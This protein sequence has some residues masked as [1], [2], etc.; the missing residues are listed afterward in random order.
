[1]K[2]KTPD[3]ARPIEL[4]KIWRLSQ[5]GKLKIIPALLF[6]IT[7][8]NSTCKKPGQDY[9]HNPSPAV[10]TTITSVSPLS[11][12]SG[13]TIIIVGTNFNT[14]P[15][16]DTVK[17]D[18]LSAQ[19]ERATK[20]TLFVIVPQGNGSGSVTVNG[21]LAPGPAFAII[22]T[23]PIVDTP[24]HKNIY[25]R[26][27]EFPNNNPVPNALVGL[28]YIIADTSGNIIS[29]NSY[30]VDSAYSDQNGGVYFSRLD[31]IAKLH[32]TNNFNLTSTKSNFWP[33]TNDFTLGQSADSS[34][35][36][37]FSFAWIAAHIKETVNHP[38]TPDIRIYFSIGDAV[39]TQNSPAYPQN[40]LDHLKEFSSV[41]LDT[42]VLFRTCGSC[43]NE[44]SIYN[45]LNHTIANQI[46]DSKPIANKSDTLKLEILLP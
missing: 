17:I 31:S 23:P 29:F 3:S 26:V 15:L 32:S 30:A 18:G 38:D 43:P 12:Q 5:I 20:D 37:V 6:F 25:A 10:N 16:L 44:I 39:P 13:D 21:I 34:S 4:I 42:V 46:Y 35:I 2:D 41:N 40:L 45:S 24:Q 36:T 14:N 19:V 22:Q 9:T 33:Q 28:N 7:L 1:M 27:V 11:A 8:L